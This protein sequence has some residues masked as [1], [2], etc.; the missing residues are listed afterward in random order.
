MR[1]LAVGNMYP[2]HHLGGYELC[3]R[4]AVR[5]LRRDGH[6]AR[7]LTTDYRRRDPA[8]GIDEDP[9][10]HRELRWYWHEHAW[11]ELGVRE[12]LGLER[13]NA[14]RFDRHLEEFRPDL[15]TWWAMGGMSLGLIERARRNGIPALLFVH[16]YW[17]SYG[18]ERDL[19][20][21]MW[22][23][24]PRAAAVV[25]RATGLPKRPDLAGAGRW[26]FNSR[27]MHEETVRTG[28]QVRDWGILA[29]GIDGAYL[30]A[31]REPAP[32]WR[33]Q[34]L[35]LGRIVPQK[36]VGTAIEAMSRLPPEATLRI[37]GEGDAAHRRELEQLAAE[38]RVADRVRFEP[39][40][41]GQQVFDV[42]RACDALLFPVRW[43]EPF[44]LVPLEAMA[45]G[46]PVIATGR[47]GSADYLQDGANSLLFPAG[48]AAALAARITRLAADSA[49]RDRLRE[50]G[51]RTAAAHGEDRFNQGA[52]AEMLAATG[53]STQSATLPH[54]TR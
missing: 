1:V 3:C 33:W 16:D 54:G 6:E 40:R 38:L 12:R 49:L 27:S 4:G 42:Y 25:E 37:V 36:G 9:D 8:P 31:A 52:V 50:G 26:L 51:Y 18:P 41:L 47:G 2:P 28:L 44:G 19:W 39:P 22:R 46:R 10:V 30:A 29:P 21:R 24:R 17:P 45:L 7:V 15:V 5:R 43:P 20:T 23:W 14:A 48:D 13:H 34:L 53:T 35:Y 11:P 32:P